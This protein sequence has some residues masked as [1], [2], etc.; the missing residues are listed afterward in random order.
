MKGVSGVDGDSPQETGKGP[1]KRQRLHNW[2]GLLAKKALQPPLL[3]LPSKAVRYE[4]R[5]LLVFMKE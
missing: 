5:M 4:V 1:R 3:S 2:K